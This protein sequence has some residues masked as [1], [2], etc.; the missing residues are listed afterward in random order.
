MLFGFDPVPE[1]E[2]GTES[3]FVALVIETPRQPEP[4]SEVLQFFNAIE[5]S[6]TSL[7]ND[8]QSNPV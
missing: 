8:M 5:S 1:G 4:V 2:E 6:M 7:A 3:L